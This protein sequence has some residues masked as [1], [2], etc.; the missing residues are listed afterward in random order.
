MFKIS[1]NVFSGMRNQG[2]DDRVRRPPAERLLSEGIVSTVKFNEGR[3]KVLV[4]SSCS[5]VEPSLTIHRKLNTEDYC[6]SL[7]DIGLHALWQLYWL[8]PCYFQ[9]DNASCHVGRSIMDWH[10]DNGVNRMDLPA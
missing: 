1:G 5:F 9:C 3:I 6:T 10:G 8:Y 4:Y 7:N 2:S